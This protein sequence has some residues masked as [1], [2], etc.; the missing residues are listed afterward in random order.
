MSTHFL[1]YFFLEGHFLHV[2]TQIADKSES[3]NFPLQ[4]NS[5]SSN[6]FPVRTE[7]KGLV[8]H[9][10]NQSSEIYIELAIVTASKI[11]ERGSP[12]CAKMREG[13]ET[14]REGKPRQATKR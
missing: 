6:R 10:G 4:K 12:P 3:Q 2:Q 8:D 14:A 1:E 11:A 13:G 9:A 5:S 7:N